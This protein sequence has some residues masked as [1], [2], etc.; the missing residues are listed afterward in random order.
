VTPTELFA[1]GE[2][3]PGATGEAVP[4]GATFGRF[5]ALEMRGHGGMGVVMEAYDPELDRKVAIKLLRPDLASEDAHAALQREAQAMA[6]LTHPNVVTVYEVGRAEEL[7]FIAM[8]LVDGVTL[9]AWQA[10][11]RRWRE[12]IAMLVGAG[13]GL[14]AAHQVGLVH[15]D[16]KPDNV[17]I[18]RDGRPRVSDFGLAA[19]ATSADPTPRTAGT[20]AYMSPEQWQG[21]ALD[22]RSDQFSFCVA[23]WRA[24]YRVAPFPGDTMDALRGAVL[25]G[26][27]TPPPRGIAPSWLARALERGLALDPEARWPQ[28]GALLDELESRVRA[29]KRATWLVAGSSA[30]AAAAIAVAVMAAS[31]T[32]ADPCRIPTARTDAVWSESRRAKLARHTATIDPAVGPARFAAIAKAFDRGIAAWTAMYGSACRA[33]RVDGSQSD[34]LLDLRMRCLDEWLGRLDGLAHEVEAAADPAQLVAAVGGVASIG[35]IERCA[36][37]TLLQ[38]LAPPP[39]DPAAAAEVVAIHTQLASIGAATRAGAFTGLAERTDALIARARKIDHA[40]VVVETLSAR[41]QLAEVL[42]DIAGAV[43]V[44]HEV[45]AVGSRAHDDEHVA[46][47]WAALLRLVGEFQG[48]PELAKAMI[49]AARAA[50]ARLGD[51]PLVLALVLGEESHALAS[52]GDSTGALADLTRARQLLEAAGATQPGSPAATQLVGLLH[53]LGSTLFYAGE[54]EPAAVALRDAIARADAT[55]GPDT[56]VSASAY[57][58]LGQVLRDQAKMSEAEAALAEAVRIRE[59]RTGSSTALAIALGVYADT[60]SMRGRHAEAIVA[61]ERAAAILRVATDANDSMRTTILAL[62]ADIY[63]AA[64]RLPEALATYDEVFVIADRGKFDIVNVAVWS[65]NR[66]DLLREA[67]RCTDAIVSYRRGGE[68]GARF[69][70]PQSHYL[71]SAARGE[72]RCLVDLHRDVDAI[73]AFERSLRYPMPVFLAQDEQ[74]ARIELGKLLIST[75]RDRARGER[76]VRDATDALAKLKAEMPDGP[77]H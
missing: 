62:L 15:C 17:L 13:R 72:A 25:A 38:S 1:I 46:R 18:G 55:F 20:P 51:P 61:G 34:T 26:R 40:P 69:E 10:Q 9:T 33:T 47:A 24:I 59:A 7:V 39:S 70:G 30:A 74:D 66:A 42:G 77:V 52:A 37:A 45:I 5:E 53:S 22:A 49:P 58:T 11:P 31:H 23:V 44:L 8:E 36:D 12:V 14:E 73:A 54:L 27:I 56:T 3:L 43:A 4:I 48:K 32:D 41:A 76:M 50:S 64:H 71:G 28:L 60:V 16:F 75:G 65:V 6:Q 19:R 21:A 63:G 2:T 68:V 29:R 35:V 67:H 57:L